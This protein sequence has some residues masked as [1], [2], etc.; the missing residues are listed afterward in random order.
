MWHPQSHCSTEPYLKEAHARKEAYV[1]DPNLGREGPTLQNRVEASTTDVGNV[2]ATTAP[3][4]W[5]YKSSQQYT[6]SDSGDDVFLQ[7]CDEDTGM[8]SYK[9]DVNRSESFT[10]AMNRFADQSRAEG[11]KEQSQVQSKFAQ[12]SKSDGSV[13]Q[14][15]K[16]E[17]GSKKDDNDNIYILHKRFV[18]NDT[19]TGKYQLTSQNVARHNTNVDYRQ[20]LLEEIRARGRNRAQKYSQLSDNSSVINQDTKQTNVECELKHSVVQNELDEPMYVNREDRMKPPP[21]VRNSSSTG[22]ANSSERNVI[23]VGK[24]N[25]ENAFGEGLPMSPGNMPISPL[26]GVTAKVLGVNVPKDPHE[27][28]SD[29]P[30][31]YIPPRPPKPPNMSSILQSVG[32]TQRSDPPTTGQ[33]A[34]TLE[35]LIKNNEHDQ[36]YQYSKYGR[37]RTDPDQHET[38]AARI[39]SMQQSV[40]AKK[41]TDSSY[42][43]ASSNLNTEPTQKVLTTFMPLA[44]QTKEPN[45]ASTTS[46]YASKS[47]DNHQSEHSETNLPLPVHLMRTDTPTS[48]EEKYIDV[49]NVDTTSDTYN[50]LRVLPLSTGDPQFSQAPESAFTSH[51]NTQQRQN[52]TEIKRYS[53][54]P[55]DSSRNYGDQTTSTGTSHV[56]TSNAN[57]GKSKG[58]DTVDRRKNGRSNRQGI[59]AQ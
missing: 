29:S 42:S 32:N 22:Y 46:S 40:R 17:S 51:R 44:K 15:Y 7:T 25:S 1:P 35:T 8:K 43:R 4:T 58:M 6:S 5:R 59:I 9:R 10:A 50:G 38:V 31:A 13:S 21:P 3:V 37:I 2:R 53:Y 55:P 14:T 24:V 16:I 41:S 56:T 28:H 12:R 30:E 39:L 18:G 49:S 19:N 11:Q 57:A 34:Q 45:G 48:I 33:N 20:E 27:M 54:G 36:L 52:H 47:G 23:S 26:S